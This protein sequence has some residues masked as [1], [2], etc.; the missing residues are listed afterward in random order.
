MS[1][2]SHS[3]GSNPNPM[4]EKELID[5]LDGIR[6]GVSHN[7]RCV[8]TNW[9]NPPLPRSQMTAERIKMNT[10]S[11]E[12]L[13]EIAKQARD[14][15]TLK[16]ALAEA[17]RAENATFRAAQKACEDCDAPTMKRITELEAKMAEREAE[18]AAMRQALEVV[19]FP[20][21]VCET[22]Q[23]DAEHRRQ[24]VKSALSTQAGADLLAQLQSLTEQLEQARRDAALKA[25]KEAQ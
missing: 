3:K 17:L 8:D 23:K 13:I 4:N 5:V 19:E 22:F 18:C 16:S 15:A 24:V 14:L 2:S 25:E 9:Y 21:L 20:Y 7:R 11:I 12:K 1:G 10:D 6:L